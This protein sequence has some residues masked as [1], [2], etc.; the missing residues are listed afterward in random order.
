MISSDPTQPARPSGRRLIR[1]P[2]T[3]GKGCLYGCLVALAA[4]LF[5]CGLSLA[6]YVVFPPPPLDILVL[7][8]DARP[9]EGTVTRADSI[10]LMGVHPRHV[11]LLSIPRDLFFE[12]EGY[13]EQRI[14][15]IHMLG[16][17]EAP[18]R[19]VALMEQSIDD[20]FDIHIDRYLRLDF[21]GFVALV[22]AVGGVTINVEHVIEDYAYPTED[23]GTITVHFDT[24]VQMMD[25]A[26]ALI[27]ARTRHGDDDYRRAERQ[28]Q[29]ISALAGK[30]LLPWN[31]PS[32][33]AA[34]S[35]AADTDITVFDMARYAPAF[36]V[37]LGR[38]DRQVIDRDLITT[39]IN[40]NATPDVAALADWIA[41]RFD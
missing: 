20:A 30:L 17:M 15:A 13:G 9:G 23:G 8:L 4:L 40:G 5:L 25:G 22:D 33:L 26:R 19:G 24:G 21:D 37:N 27:Y 35:Q 32:A 31:W 41:E 11:S 36:L 2:D 38:F 14:N 10:I 6:I 16:E 34:I 28:Q 39:T 18:G 29:V 12:A 3:R 1:R 7:G